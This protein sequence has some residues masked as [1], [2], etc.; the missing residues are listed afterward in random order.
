WIGVADRAVR[1][2]P[3]DAET[4]EACGEA[5]GGSAPR[6]VLV[7]EP[8]AKA[9]IQSRGDHE[10][11]CGFLVG[12]EPHHSSKCRRFHGLVRDQ[13]KA[14]SGLRASGRVGRWG[15]HCFLSVEVLS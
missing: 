11:L 1:V 10:H 5:E 8:V 9:R 4:L 12:P 6:L 15:L 2:D 14:P 7:G 3:E 13:K